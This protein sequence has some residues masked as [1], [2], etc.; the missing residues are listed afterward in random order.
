MVAY[1]RFCQVLPPSKRVARGERTVT[2]TVPAGKS[3]TVAVKHP[4]PPRNVVATRKQSSTVAASGSKAKTQ[5]LKVN[6]K[7]PA[8]KASVCVWRLQYSVFILSPQINSKK[9]QSCEGMMDLE[10]LDK[11]DKL[12]GLYYAEQI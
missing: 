2:A 1:Y 11:L 7:K 10:V 8:G 3:K 9:L 5:T 4:P 6:E 12:V